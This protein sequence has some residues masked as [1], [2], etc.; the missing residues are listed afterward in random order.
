MDIETLKK[1]NDKAYSHN[2]ITREDSADDLVFYWRTQWDDNILGEST[3]SYRGQFDIIR[4]AGRDI[5]ANLSANPVQVDFEPIDLDNDD[6]AELLDG[7]YRTDDNKN[8]SQD[9]YDVAST[10]AVVCGFGAWEIYQSYQTMRDGNRNQI[11]KRRPLHGANNCVY[12]DPNAKLL[13]K[14]D[15]KYCSVIAPYS[16]EGYKDLV[17]ELTGERPDSVSASDFASPEHS[18]VFPWAGGEGE[19]IYV[20]NFYYREIAK[21]KIVTLV[22]PFGEVVEMEEG[23]L[24]DVMDDLIDAGFELRNEKTIERYKVTKY[25]ADGKQILSESIVAGQHIPVVPTYGERSILEGEE[26]Y[27]GITRLAKDP[28][29]LRNF[30]MSY[31]ADI[32][33]RSPRP[34]PIFFPE[35]LAGYENMYDA[36][37]SENNYPYLLQNRNVKGVD[38]PIGPVAQMPEQNVPTALIQSIV[39]SKEA[40]EDVANPGTP[41]NIADPDI[42]GKAVLAI[43]SK[44][45]KQTMVYQDHLKHA[46]RRDAEIYASMATEIYDSPR[47]ITVTK[48]DGT[49]QTIEMMQSIVDSDTGEIV[50]I[51]DI[52]NVEFEVYGRIGVA[53]SSQ[54][55]QTIEQFMQLAQM[56]QGTPMGQMF[57]L[58]LMQVMDTV[59]SDDIRE[60]ANKQL[61]LQG[62]KEPE[63]D[64]EKQLMAQIAQQGQQPD[65]ATLLAQAEI[66]KGQADLQREQREGR[67]LAIEA[68]DKQVSNQ[69]D[70][71]DAQTNR[72]KV[73]VDAKKAAADINIKENEQLGKN[74]DRIINNV[75]RMY[76]QGTA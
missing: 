42:S 76:V 40:V 7:L 43:Q 56:T 44:V 75:Q 24:V 23:K 18:Y 12:F 20:A 34:K 8:Y 51:N 2:Q 22:D 36:S 35:Q 62:F 3:L 27:E 64:E 17:E 6:S 61:V 69:I 68:Q 14:S 66:M 74:V 72:M 10:E 45:D 60:Y 21:V 55:E 65:A 11:I 19:K 13:D 73:V 32:V 39:M 58:K 53:Y 31:L 67:K 33:S 48:P 25:I 47:K 63:T 28:Q 54:R 4:K 71:Y 70:L 9:A 57:I 29:R 30:Q 1:L 26:H 41:Q 38:M 46:K 49:K 5:M 16:E 59:D 15:S 52:R 50:T 37:G